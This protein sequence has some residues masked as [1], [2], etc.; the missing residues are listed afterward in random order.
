MEPKNRR[1]EGFSRGPYENG[2]IC[3]CFAKRCDV[4][5]RERPYD[6]ATRYECF[7][8]PSGG[9]RD[10][11]TVAIAHW[12]GTSK[13]A[14]LDCVRAWAPPFDPAAVIAE[15]AVLVKSYGVS[16]IHGDKYAAEFVVSAWRQQGCRYT[17]SKRD[18]S[19]IYLDLL[20][21]INSQAVRLLEHDLLRRELLSRERRRG[22][23]GKDRVD[24]P[25]SA[26]DD[27]ANSA[28]GALTL[29]AKR[30]QHIQYREVIWG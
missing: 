15:A 3:C 5:V 1:A 26:H 4:G 21:L 7:C 19:T 10:K 23:A 24:H 28:A 20:Q 13:Q 14:V 29:V 25:R 6:P 27:V 30:T 11:F 18:R 9:R 12:D 16:E 22:A 8:D 2:P 17:A